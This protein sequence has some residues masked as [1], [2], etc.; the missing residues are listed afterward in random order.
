[1]GTNFSLA[2]LL[3]MTLPEGIPVSHPESA[4]YSANRAAFR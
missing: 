1:M 4:Q 2:A 3:V